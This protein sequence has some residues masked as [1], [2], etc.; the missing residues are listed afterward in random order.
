MQRGGVLLKQGDL[1]AA[2]EDFRQ[3]VRTFFRK[4]IA[5]LHFV[6]YQIHHDSNNAEAQ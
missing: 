6:I 2:A 1:G 4:Q 5:Y 3:V